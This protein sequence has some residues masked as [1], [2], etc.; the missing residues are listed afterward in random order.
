MPENN[1]FS[2]VELFAL[3][4]NPNA[5]L[6]AYKVKPQNLVKSKKE[7]HNFYPYVEKS[8]IRMDRMDT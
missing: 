4:I 1:S 3:P 6:T 8:A 2:K 5:A 7:P